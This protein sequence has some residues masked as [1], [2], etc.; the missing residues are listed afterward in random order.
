MQVVQTLDLLTRL[1]LTFLSHSREEKKNELAL[2]WSW[3]F[4]EVTVLLKIIDFQMH[5]KYCVHLNKH[6][7]TVPVCEPDGGPIHNS[8]L[9]LKLKF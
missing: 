4:L 6:Y 1:N 7:A 2:H 3:Y 9:V 8:A 5:L